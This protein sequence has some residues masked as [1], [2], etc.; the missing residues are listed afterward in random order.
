MAAERK[1]K[2]FHILLSPGE[3]KQLTV[4]AEGRGISAAAYLRQHI[5]EAFEKA[6][7]K[8]KKK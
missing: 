5:H 8:G 7:A 3:K 4:L 1:T 2:Q 6:Q